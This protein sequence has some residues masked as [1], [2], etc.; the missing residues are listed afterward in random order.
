MP[1]I[2]LSKSMVMAYHLRSCGMRSSTFR[3]SLRE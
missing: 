3:D 2:L 1:S